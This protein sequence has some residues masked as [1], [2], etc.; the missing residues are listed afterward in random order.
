M[1]KKNL[2]GLG[3]FIHDSFGLLV[4]FK[5]KWNVSKFRNGFHGVWLS[6][7]N[8][9]DEFWLGGFIPMCPLLYSALLLQY[10]VVSL[11]GINNTAEFDS[12]LL[13]VPFEFDSACVY[14]V[15]ST[16]EF[17]FTKHQCHGV[18]LHDIIIQQS[19]TPLCYHYIK[20]DS[21][22]LSVP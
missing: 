15:I 17:D 2:I 21:T 18:W 13:S 5:N 3:Y 19:L 20:F 9:I 8:D 11:Q 1:F 12:K 4:H 14:S 22:V 6:A 10:T 7:L 16:I